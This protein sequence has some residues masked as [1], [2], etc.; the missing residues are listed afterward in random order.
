VGTD[1]ALPA[2]LL[3]ELAVVLADV[4]WALSRKEDGDDA[5]RGEP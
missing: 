5:A 4:A 2:A 1:G 3:P